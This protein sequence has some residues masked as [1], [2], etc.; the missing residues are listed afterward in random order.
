M[1]VES[2]EFVVAELFGTFSTLCGAL[3]AA[4]R[5]LVYGLKDVRD[6]EQLEVQV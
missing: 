1:F 2:R 3:V 5:Y 6:K 4:L